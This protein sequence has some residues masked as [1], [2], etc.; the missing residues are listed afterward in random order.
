MRD[1]RV[2]AHRPSP[3][4]RQSFTIPRLEESALSHESSNTRQASTQRSVRSFVRR[5][6]RITSAQERA[7]RQLWPRFGVDFSPALLNLDELFGRTAERVL[8]IGFGDGESLVLQAAR[9]PELD[10]LGV[11]VHR[12]GVGHCLL[13][14]EA[15]DVRNLRLICNDAVEVLGRQIPDRSF[16]RINL[17][18]PD[19]W[20]KKRHHKRRLLQ[21]DFL[22]LVARKLRDGGALH[23]A[24]DWQNY[25]EHIDEVVADSD[26]LLVDERRV[27]D[28]DHPLDRPTT[29]FERRGLARGH[30]ITEWR[31][32]RNS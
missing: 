30:R 22:N 17:Y 18:F 29:K 19:P 14:A 15:Q 4:A 27:H 5:V 10:Y 16:E 11:E 21:P 8:E 24:T 31:L 25:A 13:R 32:V 20:P 2:S 7:I 9:N 1:W 6:G 26:S 12:P 28:G 3:T 23:I